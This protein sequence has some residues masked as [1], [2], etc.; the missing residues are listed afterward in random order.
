MNIGG[1]LGP[2]V[3]GWLSDRLNRTRVLQLSLA[4]SFLGSL[5]I[6]YLG[7]GLPVLFISLLL[8]GAV[9]YSR[10]TQTQTIIADSAT[11]EDRDAAFSLYFLLGFLSQPFWIL[12]TGYLMDTVGFAT[13]LRLLSVTYLLGICI[14]FF[15]KDERQTEGQLAV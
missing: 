2:I 3:F 9:T 14:L 5:W 11:D 10:G 12:M 8:Y 15:V 4:L 6:A 13:A 7:P 1:I